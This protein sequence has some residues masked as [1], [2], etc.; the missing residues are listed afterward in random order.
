MVFVEGQETEKLCPKCKKHNLITEMSFR[1]NFSYTTGH[2][3]TDI[4]I[5]YC[6]GCE[7]VEEFVLEESDFSY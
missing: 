5:L 7:Y 4:P 2:Y 6:E 3:T 1:D